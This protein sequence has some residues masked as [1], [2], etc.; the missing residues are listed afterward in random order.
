MSAAKNEPVNFIVKANRASNPRGLK[1]IA[2]T[3]HIADI[4]DFLFGVTIHVLI[5]FSIIQ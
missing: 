3:R 5:I 4:C 2:I 1:N